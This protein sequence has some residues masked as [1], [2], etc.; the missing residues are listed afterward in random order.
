VTFS[1]KYVTGECLAVFFDGNSEDLLAVYSFSRRHLWLDD[2]EG[3][4]WQVR[5]A[6]VAALISR[7]KSDAKRE[8]HN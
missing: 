5:D 3:I 7:K 6:A 2:S 1:S 4:A 8:G